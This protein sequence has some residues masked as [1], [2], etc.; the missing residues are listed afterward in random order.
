MKRYDMI[1]HRLQYLRRR[2]FQSYRIA[3]AGRSPST[4]CTL[5]LC[6]TCVT[7]VV[8]QSVGYGATDPASSTTPKRT[9]NEVY[10]TI[11]MGRFQYLLYTLV[12]LEGYLDF[13]ELTLITVMMPAIRCEWG[14]TSYF[15]AAIT[16]SVFAGYAV[17]AGFF[18]KIGDVYGRKP[19][20]LSATILLLIS[21][22][23]SATA[24]NK[25]VF[26]SVSLRNIAESKYRAAGISVLMLA[27]F[28]GC[29]AVNVLAYF[30][31]NAIGWRWFILVVSIQIIPALVLTAAFPESPRYLCVSGKVVELNKALEY[32]ARVNNVKLEDDVEVVVHQ[33]EELGSYNMLFNEANKRSVISLSV[34]YFANIFLEFGLWIFLPLFFSSKYCGTGSVTPKRDCTM[35]TQEDLWKLSLSSIAAIFGSLIA[36][37]CAS[38]IGRL[39][40]L[41]V[42][43]GLVLACLLG[44]L[45]C[46]SNA[47]T[48]GIVS[49]LK[50]TEAVVNTLLW[51]IIPES[52][53]TCLR[54]T[55]IG[56]INSWGKL[57]GVIGTGMV[58][59]VFYVRKLEMLNWRMCDIVQIKNNGNNCIVVILLCPLDKT[60]PLFIK[61]D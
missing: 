54:A 9:L 44:L 49:A 30:L 40:P 56:F 12:A 41:R 4:T 46:I 14:L 53:A 13:A 28:V 20:V 19:V 3:I 35:L 27:C 26:L 38:Y 47:V 50:L 8:E 10:E 36:F 60:L 51:I 24:P 1:I 61:Q 16:V 55:A 15:E 7:M 31:L 43:M 39:I 58:Y 48:F 23:L 11:G 29:A 32:M 33:N 6:V 17:C 2:L 45:I 37:L 34:V 21:A 42:A 52:F 18:G 59:L 22:L 25:W 57:G 5:L